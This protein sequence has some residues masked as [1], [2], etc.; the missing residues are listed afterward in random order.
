M[1][2]ELDDW[3]VFP[4]FCTAM[5]AIF[6][7]ALLFYGKKESAQCHT[8][9][10]PEQKYIIDQC[11]HCRGL[12]TNS[13]WVLFKTSD[14]QEIVIHGQYCKERKNNYALPTR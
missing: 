13:Y 6:G 14:G 1:F 5:L 9:V 10:W 2:D 12:N 11:E 4:L 8:V 7:F 3:E